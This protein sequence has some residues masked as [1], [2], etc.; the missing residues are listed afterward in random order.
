M[1][2]LPAC[3]VIIGIAGSIMTGSLAPAAILTGVAVAMFLM[4]STNKKP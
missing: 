3:L 1:I 4:T 2:L